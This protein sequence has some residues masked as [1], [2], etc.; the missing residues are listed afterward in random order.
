MAAAI[1]RDLWQ[2]ANPG[3]N[4]DVRSGGTAVFDGMSASEHAVS[5][6][7]ALGLDLKGHKAQSIGDL[8]DVDLVLVMTRAH[9]DA[10]LVKYPEAAEKIYTLGDYVGTGHD[11]PDPFG[12]P[13]SQYEQTASI[14]Q[15]MLDAA[16]ER[17]R[18]EGSRA[19]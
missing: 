3:W 18:T 5:A 15:V 13:R 17:I 2:K 7:K 1:L 11:V 12:G 9:R 4:L 14:L 19:E 6:M 8:A 10:L 16:V